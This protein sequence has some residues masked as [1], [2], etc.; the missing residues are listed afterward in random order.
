MAQGF[1][2]ITRSDA[3]DIARL[4]EQRMSSNEDAVRRNAD[5]IADFKAFVNEKLTSISLQVAEIRL[6]IKN[7][8]AI[9]VNTIVSGV[10]GDAREALMTA[11]S[12]H[13]R[14]DLFTKELKAL[15][16]FQNKLA[17]KVAVMYLAFALVAH[18]GWDLFSKIWR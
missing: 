18:G 1:N 14:L 10:S 9:G 5:D 7:E 16:R 2:G 12:A 17:I 8:L 3:P 15:S 6:D 4:H 13:K 11:K